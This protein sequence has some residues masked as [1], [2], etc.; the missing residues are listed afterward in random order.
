L[1]S[2][3]EPVP[4]SVVECRLSQRQGLALLISLTLNQGR[5]RRLWAFDRICELPTFVAEDEAAK[6]FVKCL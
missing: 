4:G 2:S 3:I 1:Y 5:N 6:A